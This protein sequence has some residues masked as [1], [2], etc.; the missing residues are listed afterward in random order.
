MGRKQKQD[1]DVR[2]NLG[3]SPGSQG[4]LFSGG[5]QF[6]SPE[7]YPKGYTPE[8]RRE[9]DSALT[10][11]EYKDTTAARP[12][13]LGGTES[14]HVSN[15]HY[16]RVLDT[17]ARSTIP[18]E[19]LGPRVDHY[20]RTHPLQ[21][22][23]AQ[24]GNDLPRGTYAQHASYPNSALVVPRGS[25]DELRVR[26]EHTDS[27]AVI[28]ELG[29]H[30]DAKENKT[31]FAEDGLAPGGLTHGKAEGYADSY[32]QEHFRD[33]SGKRYGVPTYPAIAA[34]NTGATFNTGY[35]IARK[36]HGAPNKN[37]SQVQFPA[38]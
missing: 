29:H 33:K 20:D 18:T 8:R 7:R 17:V 6:A 11:N 22:Q 15:E 30:H 12:N 13:G 34:G 35:D 27:Y 31:G 9:V 23:D 36:K 24:A 3:Q 5:K 21:V 1:W 28:H 37:L 38:I 10:A 32:A 19:H 25:V 2:T 26:P 4:T 16:R 14:V